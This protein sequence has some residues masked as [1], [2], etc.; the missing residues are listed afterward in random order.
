[1]SSN[2]LTLKHKLPTLNDASNY[3]RW[4][5][6]IQ[7]HAFAMFKNTNVSA[8]G[9]HHTLLNSYFRTEFRA[10][11]SHARAELE[12]GG[13]PVDTKGFNVLDPAH[14]GGNSGIFTL[15]FNHAIATGKGFRPWVY[16]MFSDIKASLGPDMAD[17]T[18]FVRH[19]DLVG[20]L[21]AVKL[22][23][24]HHEIYDPD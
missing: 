13:A 19:G 10:D 5:N 20:L 15:C 14:Y 4:L 3:Q 22:A 8:I 12:A 11:Y 6:S 16:V 7:D 2:S 9:P 18:A 21:R 1:M 23:I 24:N 17:K